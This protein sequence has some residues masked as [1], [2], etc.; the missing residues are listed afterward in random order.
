MLRAKQWP[1]V[2]FL[3]SQQNYVPL[4]VA[5]LAVNIGTNKN[6]LCCLGVIFTGN[7]T[8]KEYTFYQMFILMHTLVIPVFL[9]KHFEFVDDGR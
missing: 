6:N 7:Y 8:F 2:I 9:S 4:K 5:I 3:T 1:V